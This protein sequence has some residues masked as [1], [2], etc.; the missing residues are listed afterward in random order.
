M[1]STYSLELY[2]SSYVKKRMG[3]QAKKTEHA[4]AKNGTGAYW[5][6]KKY[7]KHESNRQRRIDSKKILEQEDSNAIDYE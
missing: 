2:N 3:N 1:D 5:G 6:R 7:A 4:G